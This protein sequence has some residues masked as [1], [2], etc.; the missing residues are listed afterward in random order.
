MSDRTRVVV[1]GAGMVGHRLVES[2][3]RVDADR[4][5][6][7][8]LVGAEEYEPYNRILLTDV[9]AGRNTLKGL[10][11]PRLPG[12]VRVLRG[13]RVTRIDRRAQ[14]V[15]LDDGSTLGYDHLV[16]ATG[17][18]PFVPP[19][20][21]MDEQPQHVH[22]LRDLDDTRALGAR[23]ANARHAVVLGGG[24]LGVEAACGL[25]GRGVAVTVLQNESQLMAGQVDPAPAAVLARSLDRLGVQVRLSSGVAEVVSAYGELVA[26]R[27]TDGTM[28][29]ADLLL[30]SCGVRPDTTLA[31]DAGL[32]VER[33][34][35][36][37]A[38]LASPADPRIHAIGDCAQP[39]EGGSGLLAPGWAQAD[40]LAA[41]LA[42]AAVVPGPLD[43]ARMLDVRL[44][45]VGVDLVA[46][47]VRPE[48]AHAEDRVI[49]V[50]DRQVGRH[51]ALVVRDDRLVGAT[52]VG[53][54]EVAAE[55][56]VM[57]ER[58]T[59]TPADP[60]AL[61]APDRVAEEP[62]PVRMPSATT[63]CRCNGVTKGAIVR[64]FE[65]GACSVEEV[66]AS[67]RATTGC[68]GCREVVCGL[69]D[70]LTESAGPAAPPP[71]APPGEEP[72][73]ASHPVA[74]VA[75]P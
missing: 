42:G 17:A 7:V 63:V 1:V 32:P 27:L 58:G 59:C 14:L 71:S 48:R 43:P 51:V 67:T 28:M 6:D 9:L 18:R 75:R 23:A 40:R 61:I 56:A 45:A 66:A 31:V 49:S 25:A 24:V 47:G 20:D 65:H 68:G 16:L 11:L 41:R 37:D 44:K 12:H 8:T 30:V 62:T 21:G 46:L 64:A 4:R 55:L 74:L 73:R 69:V 13:R 57:L 26:V 54:P 33:G 72:L 2:L 10:T 50:D 60:L 15:V 70:W 39:P 3:G 34:V 29:S 38:D 36:V 52:C 22:A 35:V 19:I 5:L 53:A